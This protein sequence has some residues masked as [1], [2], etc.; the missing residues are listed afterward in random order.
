MQEPA[1][2]TPRTFG[3]PKMWAGICATAHLT[4][5]FLRML[6]G[7]N[8]EVQLSFLRSGMKALQRRAWALK[9]VG[10]FRIFQHKLRRTFREHSEHRRMEKGCGRHVLL[11]SWSGILP[12][13]RDAKTI[14]QKTYKRSRQEEHHET[15]PLYV[16][17][18]NHQFT[19]MLLPPP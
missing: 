2:E 9:L 6:W 3:A 1:Q 15:A 19:T 11:N 7:D 8:S 14:V 12:I 18:A 17:T 4:W 16:K 10:W 5:F 13:L